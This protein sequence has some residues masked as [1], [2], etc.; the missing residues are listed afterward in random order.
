MPGP[1]LPAMPTYVRDFMAGT[2]TMS[3]AQVG[4]YWRCLMYQWDSGAVP[5]DDPSALAKVIGCSPRQAQRFWSVIGHKFRRDADGLWRNARCEH[6]HRARER[7]A[8]EQRQ[9]AL[10]RWE[11]G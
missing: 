6:E 7:F 8:A 2:V 11:V 3:P 10:L 4:A 9:K 1:T 5:A